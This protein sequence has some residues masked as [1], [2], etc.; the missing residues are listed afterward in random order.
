MPQ[1]LIFNSTIITQTLQP[2]DGRVALARSHIVQALKNGALLV[3]SETIHK[4]QLPLRQIS[5][6]KF[7]ITNH[8]NNERPNKLCKCLLAY[9]Q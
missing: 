4:N 7:K 6:I 2:T 5:A 1:N 3:Q 9:T 8:L